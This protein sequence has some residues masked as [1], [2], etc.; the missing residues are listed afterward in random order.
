MDLIP[1][2]IGDQSC[3]ESKVH[4]HLK[5]ERMSIQ[6]TT[7]LGTDVITLVLTY[8]QILYCVKAAEYSRSVNF[9]MLMQGVEAKYKPADGLT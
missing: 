2:Y 1:G 8:I 9:T 7:S 5:D 3:I 4:I 6:P